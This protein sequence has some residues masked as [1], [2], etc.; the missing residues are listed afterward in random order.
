MIIRT[1]DLHQ[2]ESSPKRRY[3]GREGW[4]H[5]FALSFINILH[6]LEKGA[7]YRPS[8]GKAPAGATNGLVFNW[9]HSPGKPPVEGLGH[10]HI[11]VLLEGEGEPIVRGLSLLPS[12][13]GGHLRHGAIRERIQTQSIG[14]SR[15]VLGVNISTKK[16]KKTWRKYLLFR[17]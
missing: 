7:L 6:L 14:Q 17:M 11:S 8:C 9:S 5:N 4:R 12:P 2:Y 10:Y 15:S 1:T 16:K 13:H 3:D